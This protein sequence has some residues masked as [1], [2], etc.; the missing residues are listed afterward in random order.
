MGFSKPG[1][2]NG[3]LLTTRVFPAFFELKY[4]EVLLLQKHSQAMGMT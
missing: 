4:Q 1:R 3:L 2:F